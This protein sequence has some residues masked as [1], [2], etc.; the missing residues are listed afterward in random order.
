MNRS[1]SSASAALL[2]LLVLVGPVGSSMGGGL[3]PGEMRGQQPM[4][5]ARSYTLHPIGRVTKAGPRA[6]LELHPELAPALEG[7]A[8]FSHV[9]VV[10][11]FHGNDRPEARTTLKVHP[12]GNPTYPLSGVFATRAP[13]RPNLIGL[14]AC[15]LVRIEGLTLE[16]EGLDAWEDSPLLDL[17]P[18]IPGLDARPEAR[19]PEWVKEILK[20]SGG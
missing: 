8:A 14:A 3:G 11:W 13:V 12:K 7:L 2:G 1:R 20:D 17:K 4:P 9:W 10:Y 18:Y 16:V 5:A 19:V 6:Q 15:R